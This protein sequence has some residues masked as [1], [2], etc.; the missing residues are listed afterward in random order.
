VPVAEDGRLVGTVSAE[1]V[2]RAIDLAQL[3]PRMAPQS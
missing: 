3:R 1:D 2:R